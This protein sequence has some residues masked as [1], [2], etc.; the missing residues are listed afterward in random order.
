MSWCLVKAQEQLY[1]HLIN[2]CQ[3]VPSGLFPSGFKT[4]ISYAFLQFPDQKCYFKINIHA[5]E[6]R[7]FE[8]KAVRFKYLLIVILSSFFWTSLTESKKNIRNFVLKA[9]CDVGGRMVL[10]WVTEEQGAIK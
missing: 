2:L 6:L 4:K 10:K 1:L 9:V 3:N 5:Y 7:V 8:V